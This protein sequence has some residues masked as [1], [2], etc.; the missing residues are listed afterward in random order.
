MAQPWL[1]QCWDGSL[2][3][4]M[5]AFI[6]REME[7]Q[8]RPANQQ[9]GMLGIDVLRWEPTWNRLY[10]FCAWP[11]PLDWRWDW[12]KLFWKASCGLPGQAKTSIRRRSLEELKSQNRGA[13][14]L[15]QRA[16]LA[17]VGPVLLSISRCSRRPPAS[18]IPGTPRGSSCLRTA[19]RPACSCPVVEISPVARRWSA[20]P[21]PRSPDA[22]R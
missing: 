11:L 10:F 13:L 6:N 5:T 15:A 7:E 1:S 3:V 12:Q 9:S 17:P 21:V 4:E 20:A 18:G 14:R 19:S 2:T 22:R 16:V 8:Q